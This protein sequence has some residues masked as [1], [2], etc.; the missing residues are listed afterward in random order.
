MNNTNQAKMIK[1]MLEATI[2]A[3]NARI[4]DGYIAHADACAIHD[5]VS[6]LG[7]YDSHGDLDASLRT[8]LST[9]LD[10]T[11]NYAHHQATVHGEV[12]NPAILSSIKLLVEVVNQLA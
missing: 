12:Q 7:K 5:L 3:N 11:I 4:E 1:D 6:I 8:T 10:S 9:M 2:R